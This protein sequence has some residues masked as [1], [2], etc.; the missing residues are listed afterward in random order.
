MPTK[1]LMLTIASLEAALAAQTFESRT[2][3]AARCVMAQACAAELKEPVRDSGSFYAD[4]AT[5]SLTVEGGYNGPH[6]AQVRRI[7]DL[8]R[9][10]N[11]PDLRRMLPLTVPVTV[12]TH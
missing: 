6:A 10:R 5:Q 4:T 12:V 3:V 11:I 7:I 2:P 9:E 8:F 1:M